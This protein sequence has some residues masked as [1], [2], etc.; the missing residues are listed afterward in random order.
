MNVADTIIVRP[1]CKW[2]EQ[3]RLEHFR[4]HR[5]PHHWLDSGWMPEPER[6][7]TTM[8]LYAS[9]IDPNVR[10]AACREWATANLPECQKQ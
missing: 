8:R 9:A 3:D 2:S 5:W 7:R 4:S 6:R 1:W 10:E